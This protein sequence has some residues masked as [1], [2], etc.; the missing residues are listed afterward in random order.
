[1]GAVLVLGGGS[2]LGVAIA[3]ALAPDTV[4]LGGR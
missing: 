3:R 2:V 4:V 1:V